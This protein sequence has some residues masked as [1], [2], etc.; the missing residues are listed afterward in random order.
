MEHAIA[1]QKGGDLV[2]KTQSGVLK[3]YVSTLS[4]FKIKL[5]T[6]LIFSHSKNQSIRYTKPM[7]N[8][9]KKVKHKHFTVQEE[10][11]EST[12]NYLALRIVLCLPLSYYT[13]Q[14]TRDLKMI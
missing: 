14:V 9:V 2:I 5:C 1:L 6:H 11:S 7:G 13:S 12:N 10:N 8:R 4:P 3:F